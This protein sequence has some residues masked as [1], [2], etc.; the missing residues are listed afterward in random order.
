MLQTALGDVEDAIDQ[1]RLL[2]LPLGLGLGDDHRPAR[3]LDFD[4][5]GERRYRILRRAMRG[6]RH[7]PAARDARKGALKTPR[8]ILDELCERIGMLD[9][10]KYDLQ[11]SIHAFLLL[12]GRRRM[13][14]ELRRAA[15]RVSNLRRS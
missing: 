6:A 5:Q 3:N 8:A 2:P 4:A 11:R 13:A 12:I 10:A 15:A 14:N 7:D 1:R 9:V